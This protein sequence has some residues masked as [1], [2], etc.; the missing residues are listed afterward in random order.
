MP[1]DKTNTSPP[2]SPPPAGQPTRRTPRRITKKGRELQRKHLRENQTVVRWEPNGLVVSKA[3]RVGFL[4]DR[5]VTVTVPV[6]WKGFLGVVG[7]VAVGGLGWVLR[8]WGN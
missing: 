5:V 1:T 8:G 7:A 3:V 4:G 2:P 6:S